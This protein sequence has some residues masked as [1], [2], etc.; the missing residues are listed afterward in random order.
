MSEVDAGGMAVEVEPS[1]QYSITCYCHVTDGSRGAVWQIGIWHGNV[2]EAKVCH[3]IPPC[4]KMAPI[5]IHQ[6]LLD[7]SGDQAVDVS[8][9]RQWVVSFSSDDSSMKN[10]P[11]SRWPRTAVTPQNEEH[12]D[13]LIHVYTARY[14][15]GTVYRAEY[16]LQSVGNYVG[17]VGISH[18]VC[19]V[20]STDARIGTGRKL[21]GTLLGPTEHYSGM[22]KVTVPWVPWLPVTRHS[23]TTMSGSP[24][25]GEMWIHHQRKS[26]RCSL[27]WV[28]W[29]VLSFRI[30]KKWSFWT[31]WNP[32]KPSVTPQL[33]ELKAWTSRARPEKEMPF[34]EDI[35]AHC[36][37]SMDCR[38][39][40]TM[41]FRFTAFWFLSIQAICFSAFSSHG[42]LKV[43]TVERTKVA[44]CLGCSWNWRKQNKERKKV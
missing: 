40:P 24:W 12:L 10:K 25:S 13:H 14:D 9:V 15:Q 6:Q 17:N 34:S 18:S 23:A 21:Y 4:K 7:V 41:Y 2:Y 35:G 37:S 32:D 33:T 26:S 20:G 5:D 16:W 43:T 44:F 11:R 28:K 22:L 1:H 3:W 27:Q 8:T 39:P 42:L 38:T 36:Q 19:Q 30:G 29:C 31:S